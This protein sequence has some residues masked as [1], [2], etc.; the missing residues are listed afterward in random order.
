[1]GEGAG[2]GAG[3]TE[4]V[5]PTA[6]KGSRATQLAVALLAGLLGLALVVQIRSTQEDADLSGARTSD[7]VRLLDDLDERAQRLDQEAERLR[8]TRDEL[9]SGVDQ[10]AVAREATREQLRTLEVLAGTVPVQGP[11]V[12]LTVIDPLGVVDAAELLDAVQELRDAGAEA[13]EVD[14]VRWVAGSYVLDAPDGLTVDGQPLAAPYEIL[15]IGDPDTLES[16][17][18]IP[19]GVVESLRERGADAMI[20]RRTR[21]TIR[22]LKPVPVPQYARPASPSP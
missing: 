9:A 8:A 15:A 6:K 16:S 7:L 11:G 1:M 5:E 22:S 3:A 18:S 19:G 14:G 4:P 2:T 13:I 10:Q 21:L 12:V 17:L 20:E